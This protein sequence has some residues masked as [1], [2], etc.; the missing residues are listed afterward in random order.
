M[1]GISVMG[2][3]SPTSTLRAPIPVAMASCSLSVKPAKGLYFFV[4]MLFL[5]EQRIR[6]NAVKLKVWCGDL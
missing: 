4:S 3:M 1:M 5:L 6:S 2:G